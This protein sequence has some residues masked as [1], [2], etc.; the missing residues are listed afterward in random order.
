MTTYGLLGDITTPSVFVLV[1]VIV[2]YYNKNMLI[3]L[4]ISLIFSNIVKYGSKLAINNE[5][6]TEGL[7][8]NNGNDNS[9]SGNDN[10]NSGNDNSNGGNDNSNSGNDYSNSGNDN[11]NSG[12]KNSNSGNDNSNSG[13]KNSNSGNKN[14]NGGNNNTNTNNN[15][16]DNIMNNNLNNGNNNFDN[17]ISDISGNNIDPKQMKE[18]LK[19][20]LQEL[21]GKITDAKKDLDEIQRRFKSKN[22]FTSR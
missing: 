19:F 1:G 15:I 13:N 21:E 4:F 5:G 8:N 22:G 14:K 16:I 10:S 6:F 9:N 18:K 17:N 11:S 7:D 3:I 2:S 12:N 20:L